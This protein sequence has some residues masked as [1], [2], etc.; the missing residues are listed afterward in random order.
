[1]VLLKLFQKA[2]IYLFCGPVSA[3]IYRKLCIPENHLYDSLALEVKE[4]IQEGLEQ[5]KE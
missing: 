3:L 2:A 4:R 5:K 1:M